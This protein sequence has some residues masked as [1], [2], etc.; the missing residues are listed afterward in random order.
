M[1]LVLHI[2]NEIRR[3]LAAARLQ[4]RICLHARE[5]VRQPD[6][7]I[8]RTFF[9]KFTRINA[10]LASDRLLLEIGRVIHDDLVV[11]PRYNG[12]VHHTILEILR[13]KIGKCDEVALRAQILRNLVRLCLKLCERR[14]LMPVRCEHIR[15]LRRR[16]GILARERIACDP[17]TLLCRIGCHILRC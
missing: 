6:A 17:N 16:H 1:A 8:E 11:V 4:L 15:K 13:R 2:H 7:A 10:D 12:E 14:I 5:I 9:H 3:A